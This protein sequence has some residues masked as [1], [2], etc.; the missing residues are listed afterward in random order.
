MA[1][2][3]EVGTDH[4]CWSSESACDASSF[5]FNTNHLTIFETMFWVTLAL[6]QVLIQATGL[7]S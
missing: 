6:N 4:F 2:R 7:L 3:T 1:A 5:I